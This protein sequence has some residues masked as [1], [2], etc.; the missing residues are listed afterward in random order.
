MRTSGK[1]GF[2][3]SQSSSDDGAG[4][5]RKLEICVMG[6]AI[7]VHVE[8]QA[9]GKQVDVRFS[10]RPEAGK[11]VRIGK[12]SLGTRQQLEAFITVTP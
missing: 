11:R 9:G 1:V 6:D 5:R 12:L 10:A 8:R 3:C 7:H 4:N 2:A